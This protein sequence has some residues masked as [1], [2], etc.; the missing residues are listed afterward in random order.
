MSSLLPRIF[1]IDGQ[2]LVYNGLIPEKPTSHGSWTVG[3]DYFEPVYAQVFCNAEECSQL[4]IYLY[5]ATSE[6]SVILTRV[7]VGKPVFR[8]KL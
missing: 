3:S 7:S 2:A 4:W 5:D 8:H 6:H 1:C